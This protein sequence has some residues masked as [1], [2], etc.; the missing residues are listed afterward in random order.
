MVLMANGIEERFPI[1]SM[2]EGIIRSFTTFGA[3]VE[4]DKN[5]YAACCQN[6]LGTAFGTLSGMAIAEKILGLLSSFL[7]N[8]GRTSLF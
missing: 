1:G 5:V 4:I 3:F 6:G 7:H 2:V 8:N